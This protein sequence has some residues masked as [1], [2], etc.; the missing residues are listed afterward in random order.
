MRIEFDESHEADTAP[1]PERRPRST[2]S[3]AVCGSSRTAGGGNGSR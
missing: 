2:A 1:D 3:G